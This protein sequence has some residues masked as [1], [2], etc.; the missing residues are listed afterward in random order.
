MTIAQLL[1]AMTLFP[2]TN[3]VW[4]RLPRQYPG[5]DGT[6]HRCTIGRNDNPGRDIFSGDLSPMR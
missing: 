4:R 5:T 1:T 6:A 3:G 2:G